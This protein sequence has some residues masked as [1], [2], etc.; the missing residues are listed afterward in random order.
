M[1]ELNFENE[2]KYRKIENKSPD[3]FYIGDISKYSDYLGNGIVE[4]VRVPIKMNHKSLEERLEEPI[5]LKK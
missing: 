3:S 1:T 5:D 2:K 4:E